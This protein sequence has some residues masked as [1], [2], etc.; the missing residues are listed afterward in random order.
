MSLGSNLD[1]SNIKVGDD[2]YFE[3]AAAARPEVDLVTWRLNVSA[4]LYYY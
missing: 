2:V 4:Q 1:A 3:C